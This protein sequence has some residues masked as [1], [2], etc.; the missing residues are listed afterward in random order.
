[1]WITWATDC[2]LRFLGS[3]VVFASLL[4]LHL[5]VVTAVSVS[6]SS[7]AYSRFGV[8]I[9]RW[10]RPFWFSTENV[11]SVAHRFSYIQRH[12]YDLRRYRVCF[13]V[14]QNVPNTKMF[15]MGSF[16]LDYVLLAKG[17]VLDICYEIMAV[18]RKQ[19]QDCP[20]LVIYDTRR[21]LYAPPISCFFMWSLQYCLRE[22]T[23]YKA[24]HPFKSQWLLYVPPGLTLKNS[25]FCPHSVCMCRLCVSEQIAIIS[26]YNI[27]RL[28]CITE[29]EIVYCVVRTEFLNTVHVIIRL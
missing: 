6:S 21:M 19:L 15:V 17:S 7:G 1:L 18:F 14:S 24:S 25:A 29:T 28:V 12:S 23:S 10:L 8:F 11:L 4:W 3:V 27:N 13:M 22:N 5:Q 16:R 20:W 2:T 26:L 9:F